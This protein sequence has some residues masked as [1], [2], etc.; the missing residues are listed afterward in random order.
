MSETDEPTK[1][2]TYDPFH[3]VRK[4]GPKEARLFRVA[5]MGEFNTIKPVFWIKVEQ[6]ADE[7]LISDEMMRRNFEPYGKILKCHR[8]ENKDTGE[9]RL[10]SL[11][12]FAES[13]T[14]DE[15]MESWGPVE[16]EERLID[17]RTVTV[18]H[19]K[20]WFAELYPPPGLSFMDT[21]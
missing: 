15:V 9:P 4:G 16:G 14:P 11:V 6:K 1:V 21:L 3:N 19:A 2:D 5:L 8:P 7:E 13:E 20:Q 18:S 10:F 12:G 17:G